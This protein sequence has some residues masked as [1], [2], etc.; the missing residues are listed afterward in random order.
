M[1]RLRGCSCQA[2]VTGLQTAS[3]RCLGRNWCSRHKYDCVVYTMATAQGGGVEW[4]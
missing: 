1:C 4:Q 2:K 3:A